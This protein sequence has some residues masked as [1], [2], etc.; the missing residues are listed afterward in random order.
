MHNNERVQHLVLELDMNFAK[1]V[2]HIQIYAIK[3][4]VVLY[5]DMNYT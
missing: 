2:N 3:D 5:L 1:I 4:N